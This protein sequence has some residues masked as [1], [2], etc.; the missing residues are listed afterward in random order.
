MKSTTHLLLPTL[1]TFSEAKV[2]IFNVKICAEFTQA[3]DI[4]NI[5]M[6]WSWINHLN[7]SRVCGG[8]QCW[9]IEFF[10]RC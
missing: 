1:E 3:V 4:S 7:T 6:S 10:C 5:I 9:T 8:S 2:H